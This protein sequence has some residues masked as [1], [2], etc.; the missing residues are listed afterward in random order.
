MNRYT[1][2]TLFCIFTLFACNDI[3]RNQIKS[4]ETVKMRPIDSICVAYV[5]SHFNGFNNEITREKTSKAMQQIVIDTL[6]ANS[7]LLYDLP[8]K[9]ESVVEKGSKYIV[10]FSTGYC[11]H[12][13]DRKKCDIDLWFYSIV[14]NEVMEKLKD[15]ETY[16]L[17]KAK[18]MGQVNDKIELPNGDTFNHKPHIALIES[19]LDTTY[20]IG[21]GGLYIKD[22]ELKEAESRGVVQ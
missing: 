4:E 18:F 11:Y 1:I 10:R 17:S 14:G 6:S 16:Y 21:L 15:K 9:Y 3:H 20:M 12:W 22:I 8:L 5:E 2:I 7:E 19:P 13:T